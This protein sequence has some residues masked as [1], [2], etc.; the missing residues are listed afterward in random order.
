MAW[1]LKYRCKACGYEAEV[2]DGRGLFR[3]QITAMF[4]P[5]C[6]TV[7]NI[8]VG[9]IIADVAP[10][11]RSEVGR[12]CLQC[13]S[14]RIRIWDKKTCPK[15][16]SKREQNDACIDSAEREHT[17]PEVKCTS[18]REQNVKC[19]GTMEPTGEKEFWT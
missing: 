5:D 8:V 4:C 16:T 12:L 9:G 11:F 7:Q 19:Q 3:Q 2:Y 14:D 1:K 18:K 17:R 10:S 13:G 6:K 15:C